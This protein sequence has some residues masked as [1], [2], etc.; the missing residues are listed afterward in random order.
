M[1]RFLLLAILVVFV[2]RALSRLTMGVLEG[3]GYRRDSTQSN[4][5]SVNL[6]RDPVCG[7]FVVRAKALTAAAGSETKYFCSDKCRR[8][9]SATH[10]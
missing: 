7:M 6:V 10:R 5:P 9:W 3:A 2:V 8:E 1:I 4:Q